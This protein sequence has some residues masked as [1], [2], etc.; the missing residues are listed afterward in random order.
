[1]GENVTK[2]QMSKFMDLNE[3]PDQAILLCR[4]VPQNVLKIQIVPVLRLGSVVDRSSLSLGTS[5]L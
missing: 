3:N 5:Q 4:R 2:S 1:M